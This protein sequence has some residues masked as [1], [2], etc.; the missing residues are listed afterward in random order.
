MNNKFF[1]NN[2][3]FR[4]V[5]P[6]FSGLIMYFMILMFF[7]SVNLIFDDFFSEEIMFVIALT[8][9]LSECLRLCIL[10]LNKK[11]VFN[12]KIKSRIIYQI[13]FTSV[14]SVFLVSILL[15]L[16]FVLIVGFSTIKTELIVFNC[17]YLLVVFLYNL[18]YFSIKFINLKNEEKIIEEN[19]LKRNLELKIQTYKTQIN[20][21][22]LFKSL[23]TII[24]ELYCNKESA[25]ELIIGLSKIYRYTLNNRFNDLVLVKDELDSLT[26][27]INILNVQ[28]N[29]NI[30]FDI[31][32]DS[33]SAK[34]EIVPGTF[35]AI[36]E[37]AVEENIITN[38]L[39]LNISVKSTDN[40]IVVKYKNNSHIVNK[41]NSNNR[42]K[43]IENAYNYFSQNSFIIN[44]EQGFKIYKITLL[45]VEEEI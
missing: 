2:A 9:I 6:V 42:I 39:P 3:V 10:F 43:Y 33:H 40:S 13:I 31:Q 23:E 37:K 19:Q 7:D 44:E 32:I 5:A 35:L 11:N 16:Y 21:N 24:S 8:F 22:L 36:A 41:N 1:H 14:L 12:K 34:S 38:S 26:Y 28:Y 29:G 18:F 17:L 27:F 15:H 20:P 45:N 25:D 30:N 4:I